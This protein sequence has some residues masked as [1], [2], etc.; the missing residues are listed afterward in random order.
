VVGE[1]QPIR[2]FVNEG[3]RFRDASGSYIRFPSNGWW[4]NIICGDFDGDGDTD[5]LIGNYGL[6]TQFSVSD[7]EPARLYCKDFDQNGK[8]DPV[9]AYYI[10]HK[11]YP[12]ASLDDLAEQIPFIRK[13]YL[14]YENYAK[15]TLEDLLTPDMRQGMEVLTLNEMQTVYLENK[16]NKTFEKKSLP[17]EVQWSPVFAMASVDLNHDGA[18]DLLVAGNQSKTRIKYGRYNAN[19]GMVLVNDGKGNFK[20]YPAY[21]TGLQLRNDVRSLV[22]DT[23]VSPHSVLIGMDGKQLRRY[24]LTKLHSVD[25]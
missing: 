7:R 4:T 24:V 13:R 17:L 21:Q 1:F 10:Q 23:T 3:N 2:V 19:H 9:F 25:K 15:A 14:Q 5:L 8:I 22:M 18:P 12:M 20:Y 6:N 11:E 16:N